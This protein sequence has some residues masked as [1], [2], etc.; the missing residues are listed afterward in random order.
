MLRAAMAEA[1]PYEPTERRL[2]EARRRGQVALS[3]DGMRAAALLGAL[4]VLWATGD[5]ILDALRQ[6]F[7]VAF[8]AMRDGTGLGETLRACAGLGVSAVAPL[9]AVVFLAAVTTGFVQ[10]GPLFAAMAVTRPWAVDPA[11]GLRGL[12][13]G[14]RAADLLLA[15]VKVTTVGAVAWV[16]LRDAMRG[17][18]GLMQRDAEQALALAGELGFVLC[19][20]VAAALAVLAVLDFFYQRYRYRQQ[21]RMTRWEWERE[22]RETEGDPRVRRQRRRLHLQALAAAELEAARV[23]DLM[24][25]AL[26]GNATAVAVRLAAADDAA[27]APRVTGAAHGELGW[28]MVQTAAAEGVAMA[29]DEALAAELGEVRPG[30]RVPERLYGALAEVLKEAGADAGAVQERRRRDNQQD[31]GR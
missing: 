25:M 8:A 17:V 16:T 23:A 11:R 22:R 28:R 2:A 3:R 20:R 19:I 1:R 6:S 7:A 18:V 24:V 4:A 13:S 10:V 9:L 27:G 26:A 12:L 30:E 21:L 29:R 31:R 14:W 15:A 5:D